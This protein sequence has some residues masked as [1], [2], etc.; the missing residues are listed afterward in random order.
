M[1]SCIKHL[2]SLHP[3]IMNVIQKFLT[4]VGLSQLLETLSSPAKAFPKAFPKANIE[5]HYTSEPK[6]ELA[7]AL[8]IHTAV[9]SPFP[10]EMAGPDTFV[11]VCL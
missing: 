3:L 4:F 10:V 11:E 6:E 7:S 1:S 2:I 5:P 8:D 9:F